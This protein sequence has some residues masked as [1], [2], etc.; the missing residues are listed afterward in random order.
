M[1]ILIHRTTAHDAREQQQL[2]RFS[3]PYA[4]ELTGLAEAS[5][6]HSVPAANAKLRQC[7]ADG[8]EE[9]M[10]TALLTNEAERNEV[11]PAKDAQ[12][13]AMKYYG[14]EHV[15]LLVQLAYG[16]PVKYLIHPEARASK[17]DDHSS[18]GTYRGPSRDRE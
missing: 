17:F 7:P 13:P 4:H 9:H 12:S 11:V 6:R 8:G 10:Y 15:E 1:P 14:R 16:A 2:Q 18:P 3:P 5:F